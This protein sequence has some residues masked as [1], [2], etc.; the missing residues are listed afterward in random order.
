VPCHTGDYDL[1]IDR[2]ALFDGSRNMVPILLG[3]VPFGL[4]A[5]ITAISVGLEPVH[6]VA[7]SVIVFA[8]AAQLAAL[9]LI[10]KNA[11]LAVVAATA[12]IINARMVMYSASLAPYFG[13]TR[14][15]GKALAA[16]LLT[17]QAYAFS[18]RR[19]V[20]RDE[21]TATRLSYYLGAGATLWVTWQISTV[22]GALVGASIPAPWSLDFAVPLVFIALLVPAIRDRAD[23]T[24]AAVAAGL[25]VVLASLP[26]NLGLPLATLAGIGAGVFAERRGPS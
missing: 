3:I 19:F 13:N 7:M 24:A 20:D 1:S 2:S 23:G 21:S 18:I 14:P 12:L 15:A 25:S 10:G 16:Y 5:G 17:D 8:G 9:D 4:I 6:G 22:V 26:Y 11:P